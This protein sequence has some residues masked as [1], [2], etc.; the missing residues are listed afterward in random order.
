MIDEH[1]SYSTTKFLMWNV[2]MKWIIDWWIQ[3]YNDW[4]KFLYKKRKNKYK[5]AFENFFHDFD[6]NDFESRLIKISNLKKENVSM[7]Q[8]FANCVFCAKKSKK[9]KF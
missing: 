5:L 3:N 6:E 8:I 4:I 7:Q 2:W 1:E 9:N